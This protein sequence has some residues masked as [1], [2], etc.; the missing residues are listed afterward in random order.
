MAG[1]GRTHNMCVHFWCSPPL[2]PH[3]NVGSGVANSGLSSLHA[4]HCLVAKAAVISNIE[5]GGR[6]GRQGQIAKLEPH[7]I[8]S[9]EKGSNHTPL[10][11][12]QARLSNLH[13]NLLN[14][15]SPIPAFYSQ[16]WTPINGHLLTE[17]EQMQSG[18]ASL[19]P[20]LG[21]ASGAGKHTLTA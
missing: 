16:V 3:F 14:A 20:Q 7:Y 2:P 4:C 19:G 17:M 1:E 11:H 6:R 9:T 12:T 18:A 13:L 5:M 10:T 21:L 8:D 15:R